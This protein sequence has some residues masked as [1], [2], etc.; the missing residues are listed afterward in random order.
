MP[1]TEKQ[2][3]Y[4][5][6][7]THRWNIKTGATGSGKSHVDMVATIP[8]R[9]EACRGEGLIVF[10]GNTQGTLERNIFEPMRSIWPGLVSSIHAN[11]TIEIWGKKVYAL[12]ADKKDRVDSIRGP[13]FEYVY[14]DE[15][16]TW[17]PEVFNM[18]KS[19][20]R[21]PHSRFDGTGNP[22]GPGHWFKKF[23]DSDADIY[24]QH[25]HIDDGAL[26][27]YIIEQLKKEYAG[28]VYYQRYI[29]GLWVAAEGA[30]YRPWCDSM[31]RFIRP[32][33]REEIVYTTIGVD[34][35]GT[36][37]ANAFVCVGIHKGFTGV[38]ILR[39]YYRKEEITPDM[40]END[41]IEFATSCY[42]D[43]GTR[44]VRC[45]SAEQTLINGLTAAAMKAGLPLD[46]GNAIKGPIN[47][48]IRF[49]VRLMGRGTFF[50]DPGCVHVQQALTEAVYKDK[51]IASSV[52]ERLDDGT[53]NIDSLDAMEYAF[54]PYM[55]DIIQLSGV[56]KRK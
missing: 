13:S 38:S 17:S 37:S 8:L 45:D 43:F 21:C 15:V 34:F 25:Y 3:A 50:V 14:G 26:P 6:N 31:D 9:L 1:L 7:A 47:E 19:R 11:N 35:G 32:T 5:L 44:E 16:P 39:E 10:L 40:L 18:L 49:T 27:P 4:L 52:G 12:G 28:T 48:R 23:L 24:H 20:L 30:V 46:I 22:E 2:Q 42:E 55:N 56:R 41:F 36:G 54:E 51:R 29:L 53:T 33:K